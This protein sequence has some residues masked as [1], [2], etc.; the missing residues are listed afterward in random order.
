MS[1]SAFDW[2]QYFELAKVLAA[3]P[4]ESHQR[5]AIS[6]SYYAVF[7]LSRQYVERFHKVNTDRSIHSQ[8]WG[9]LQNS[10]NTD[11]KRL[12]TLGDRMRRRR[13]QADYNDRIDNLKRITE[14]VLIKAEQCLGILTSQP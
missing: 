7:C 3:A 2:T 5:S 4:I 6:R 8:V 12:A 13:N 10:P 9:W 1:S 14:D 11:L